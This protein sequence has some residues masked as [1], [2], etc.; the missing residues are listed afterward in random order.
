MSQPVKM[1]ATL[2]AALALTGCVL[3]GSQA[4]T[5]EAPQ[6]SSATVVEVVDGDTIHVMQAGRREKVRLIGLDAPEY[7][8]SVEPFGRE[9]GEYARESLDGA[10]VWL[11]RDAE[12]RDR[13]GR[14]LAY[15]WMSKPGSSDPSEVR[16]KLF[17]AIIVAE[18]Y[19]NAR[20]Y[21]PNVRYT[22]DLRAAER[23]ARDA[24]RGLWADR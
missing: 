18:G 12:L 8:K 14:E 6:V 15:V 19:A 17:N 7:T 9:A 1:A 3:A 11:E 10:H 2:V 21:P 24:R 20:T 23:E 5:G 4:S 16:E 22:D 13:Y